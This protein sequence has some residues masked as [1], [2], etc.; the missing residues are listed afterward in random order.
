MQQWQ[1]AS[2]LNSSWCHRGHVRSLTQLPCCL[3]SQLHGLSQ[4]AKAFSQRRVVIRRAVLHLC[5]QCVCAILLLGPRKQQHTVM[6]Y[7]YATRPDPACSPLPQS[8]VILH[9]RAKNNVQLD[10]NTPFIPK[11]FHVF[12]FFEKHSSCWCHFTNICWNDSKDWYQH[13][14]WTAF[15]SSLAFV[16]HMGGGGSQMGRLLCSIEIHTNHLNC[17]FN[18]TQQYIH[19]H[20]LSRDLDLSRIFVLWWTLALILDRSPMM[21]FTCRPYGGDVCVATSQL[22]TL[23]FRW[24]V[25]FNSNSMYHEII[26]KCVYSGKFAE[27]TGDV[28]CVSP[29]VGASEMIRGLISHSETFSENSFRKKL[30]ANSSKTISDECT[31]RIPLNPCVKQLSSCTSV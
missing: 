17:G 18:L 27:V 21:F 28:W 8:W 20:M 9:Q 6:Y 23:L 22:I 12:V 15:P 14:N 4:S 26:S 7:T 29:E 30:K 11:R 25:I 31:S 19:S 2:L 1:R 16:Y 13:K 5:R 10:I 3:L 24:Y